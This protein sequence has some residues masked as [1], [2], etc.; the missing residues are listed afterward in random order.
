MRG[1][2]I[3]VLWLLHPG[4]V[5]HAVEDDVNTAARLARTLVIVQ[6]QIAHG[7]TSAL[8]SVPELR[9]RLATA[10]ERAPNSIWKEPHQGRV[11]ALH[12]LNGGTPRVVRLVLESQADL[13][14]W[15]D[16]ILALLA[17]A[18]RRGGAARRLSSFDALQLDPSIAGSLALAQAIA[19]FADPEK[20]RTYLAQARILSPG[21]LVEESAMRREIEL[22]SN[23]DKK[24]EAAQ[25]AARYLWRFGSSLY[26]KDVVVFLAGSLIP[27]LSSLPNGNGAVAALTD[28]LPVNARIETLMTV[29]RNAL[30]N[31]R[32]AAAE[33]AAGRVVERASPGSYELS[34]ATL[35]RGI[36]RALTDP[37]VEAVD[38]L[39]ESELSPL[40]D[41][42]RGLLQASLW[43]LERVRAPIKANA[44]VELP[45][46]PAIEAAAKAL[47]AARDQLDLRRP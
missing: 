2:M 23:S 27:E 47:G 13:G 30:L 17:Y 39:R 3:F 44:S 26:V 14:Q 24:L 21:G 38:K 7:N 5:A 19:N 37:T 42:D 34:R 33:F 40:S 41:E 18:E 35:Y 36:V 28:E 25:A 22:L 20:A 10:I 29:A 6:D 15:R 32:V 11:L 43:A 45:S 8:V 12:L 9:R 16:M 1:I 31:G 46:S 4:G